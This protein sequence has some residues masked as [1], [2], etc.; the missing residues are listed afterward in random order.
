MRKAADRGPLILLN[1]QGFPKPF[2][3]RNLKIEKE[4]FLDS[5]NSD[6]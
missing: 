2:N 6:K 5:K 1:F 3:G 4:V